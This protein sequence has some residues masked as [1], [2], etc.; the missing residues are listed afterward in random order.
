MG[1]R[2]LQHVRIARRALAPL[3]APALCAASL[4]AAPAALAGAGPVPPDND[5]FEDAQ[6]I[7]AAALPLH[8]NATAQANE[9]QHGGVFPFQSV[10]YRFTAPSGGDYTATTC[11]TPNSL[12]DS[13]LGVYEDGNA[14]PLTPVSGTGLG[15]D[16]ACGT[17]SRVH[18]A[19]TGGSDYL[20]AVG[21]KPAGA[22]NGELR[23][24]KAPGNDDAGSAQVLSP[25]LPT[26]ATGTPANVGA[27]K[28]PGENAHAGS[29]GGASVWY[30]WTS[31]AAQEV[32][33]DTCDQGAPPS[34]IIDTVLAVYQPGAFPLAQVAANDDGCGQRSKLTFTA[35]MGQT[36][37]IAVDG[38]TDGITQF[39]SEGS[40]DLDLVA[41]P[42]NDDFASATPMSGP[43]PLTAGGS[44]D[45]AT[46][47]G[48]EP[49]H[50]G[51]GPFQSVW[52]SWTP[53]ADGSVSIDTCE[54]GFDTRLAVYTG[55]N[56][57]APLQEVDSNDDTPG[58]G[59]GGTRSRISLEASVSAAPYRIAVDAGGVGTPGAVDLDIVEE[60]LIGPDTPTLSSV[61]KKPK[62]KATFTF[63]STD[64]I[65]SPA[66]L[67]FECRIDK[68]PFSACTSPKAYKKLKRGKHTFHVRAIDEAGNESGTASKTFKS[69][70]R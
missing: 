1:V 37:L 12:Y 56:Y 41:R 57:A 33:V 47:E 60:D 46:A 42:L 8:A 59:T 25:S 7:T 15:N 9:N 38:D 64:N 6:T 44:T 36:Y 67:D 14:L 24:S 31:P 17:K 39:A 61:I 11:N 13:T 50:A 22:L 70:R 5:D 40:F 63:S 2:L 20:I 54:S 68:K 34:P 53:Q 30:S 28:E 65:T 19:A 23:V 18:F 48:S 16:D 10:W 27:T 52:Y 55:A 29:P 26:S 62:G 49:N 21:D 3:V 32:T 58:C 51:G 43:L 69:K 66:N 35:A 4:W 45:G